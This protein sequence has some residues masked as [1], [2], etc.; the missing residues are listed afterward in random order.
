MKEQSRPLRAASR[1]WLGLCLGGLL[2]LLLLLLLL[3]L[4]I[5]LP[6]SSPPSP[7]DLESDKTPVLIMRRE[8]L[9]EKLKGP[10]QNW[11]ENH[12]AEVCSHVQQKVK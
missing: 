11:T 1:Q 10:W 2:L 8:I 9:K 5:I 3:E 6:V 4:E 7:P 12:Y